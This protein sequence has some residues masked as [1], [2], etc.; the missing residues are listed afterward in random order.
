MK[1]SS[2]KYGKRM[3]EYEDQFGNTYWSFTKHPIHTKPQLRLTIQSWVGT[4][5]ENFLAELR[6]LHR[7]LK[8][9]SDE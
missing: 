3:Y 5:F 2:A 6:A 7:V 4:H 9:S 1:K 8:D